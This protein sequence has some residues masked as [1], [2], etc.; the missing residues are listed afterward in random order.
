MSKYYWVLGVKVLAAAFITALLLSLL[1]GTLIVGKVQAATEV[2]GIIFSDITW[3]K[4]NSPYNITGPTAIAKGVTVTIEPG[5]VV[6]FNTNTLEVNG[7][8]RAIGTNAEPITLN[9]DY[10]GRLPVFGSSDYNGILEFTSE[11]NSWNAQTGT[12]CIIENANVISLSI[13]I[14]DVSVK[15]NDNV[16]SGYYAWGTVDVDGGESVISNNEITGGSL[17]IGGGSPLVSDNTVICQ[18]INVNGGSPSI[19]NN[20]LQTGI[21]VSGDSNVRIANNIIAYG[22]GFAATNG[23]VTFEHNLVLYCSGGCS[24]NSEASVIIQNNTIAFNEYGIQSAQSSAKI[25]YNNLENNTEYNLSLGSSSNFDA[26]YNWWGTTDS[27]AT[28]ETIVDYKNN[29]NLGNVTFIPFLNELNPQAP[30]IS[31][32][33]EPSP[34]PSPSQSPTSTPSPT[35]TPTPTPTQEP[36]PFPTTLVISSVVTVTVI[37]LGL[38]FYFK[39]RKY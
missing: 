26:T 12:G 10:R 37:G 15:L 24:L 28:S 7:T 32:F 1:A 38:L 30:L 21:S 5:A 35:A 39:K 3:T 13:Y 20:L 2:T 11:S 33:V 31:S 16:F 34:S 19:L 36:S 9:G 18:S 14:H 22:K 25:I 6:H 29:Y 4:A 8:L 27:S 23:N 17:S